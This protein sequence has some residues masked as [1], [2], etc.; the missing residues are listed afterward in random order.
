MPFSANSIDHTEETNGALP[1]RLLYYR[2]GKVMSAPRLIQY[3]SPDGERHV[4][5]VRD[6]HAIEELA[7]TS[8][9]LEL[10]CRAESSRKPLASII[11]DCERSSL[12]DY[13][14]LIDKQLLLP[15]ID[16]PDPTHLTL[17]G[18]CLLYTSPSPRDATLSRM[19]GW[20]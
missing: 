15:P 20:G 4:G 10:S 14:E 5:V 8:S 1:I 13:Q 18:T 6:Q 7:S 16:H 2:D 17:S 11:A 19:A 3:H 12:I 9:I